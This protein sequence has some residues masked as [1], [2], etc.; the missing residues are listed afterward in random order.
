MRWTLFLV[1]VACNGGGH[2][3]AARQTGSA[4]AADA[5]AAYAAHDFS[6]C[7]ALY[8]QVAAAAKQPDLALYNEA[9]C[10]ARAGSADAAFASIDRALA[11][12]W[13]DTKQLGSDDD[14][15]SL[16]VDPRWAKAMANATAA[17]TAFERSLKAPEVRTQL[18]AMIGVDQAQ[19]SA[20]IDAHKR[21]AGS[22][23]EAPLLD[24]MKAGDRERTATLKTI[25]DKLGWP[26]KTAVGEDGA[27]A[28]WLLV[29]HADQDPDFAKRALGLME[30]LVKPGEVDARDY[31]Y[32]YDRVAV[33]D[34]RP[35]RYGTQFKDGY[36]NP[37]EDE[38]HVDERRAAIGLGTMA[39][40]KQ[41]MRAVY[42]SDG[43]KCV[44]PRSP[45]GS[46]RGAR[47]RRRSSSGQLRS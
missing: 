1:F 17:E 35:Q 30:P 44:D 20:W 4:S 25:V 9:C 28:A 41:Q 31:A 39:A 24:A 15:A 21:N 8:A 18:L 37:I 27:H 32:L 43:A 6:R 11:A 26:N 3:D 47:S 19:R 14:L 13:H 38:A 40:Y 46:R 42:G 10:E 12:G 16:H 5:D 29:Q 33:H 22:A 34:N 2:H 7:A 45:R 36:P 23:A